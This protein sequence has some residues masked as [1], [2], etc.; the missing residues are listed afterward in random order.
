MGSD[1]LFHKRRAKRAEEI[2]RKQATRSPYEKVL[3]VCEGKKTEPNYFREIRNY[4]RLNTA[5]IEITGDSGSAP[6]SIVRKAKELCNSENLSGIPYDRVFCVFD[7]DTHNS[8]QE[9]LTEIATPRDGA[10]FRAINSVPCFEYWLLLH[11]V[12][13]NRPFRGTLGAKSAGDQVIKE[14]RKH[15][16][17]YSK[18]GNG[19]FDNLV[20]K[21]PQAVVN[22][23]LALRSAK[24]SKTDNP[25]TL[26]HVLVDFLQHLNSSC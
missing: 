2:K 24:E 23:K 18:G 13:T 19:Y 12:Y 3:I 26:V 25:T 11:F 6:I 22:S 1:N 15:I 16:H 21:L 17:N 5:N 7:K 20:A 4:Y 10:I 9:A 8:Y 14:L